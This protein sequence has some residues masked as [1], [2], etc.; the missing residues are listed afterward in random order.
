MATNTTRDA[1]HRAL[2]TAALGGG[3]T[4]SGLEALRIA[5]VLGF[6]PIA[7]GVIA[8]RPRMMAA[9]ERLGADAPT[10]PFVRELRERYG[11]GPLQLRIPGRRLA[12]VLTGTDAGRV[13]GGTPDP[14]NPANREKKGA[15]SPFQ[16]H[17]VLISEGHIR[18]ERRRVNEEALDTSHAMHHLAGPMVEVIRHEMAALMASVQAKGTLDNDEFT[19]TWWRMV[20]QIVL[21]KSARDDNTVTDQLRKLRSNGNWS[22]FLPQRRKL[23]DRFIESLYSY[24][25]KAEPGCVVSALAALPAGGAIDPVGQIPHWLFAFDAAGIASS[26]ALALLSSHPEQRRLAQEEI[27]ACDTAVPQQYP[28]LRACVLESVRLWPTTPTILRDSTSD[29]TWGAAD[30]EFTIPAGT[31]FLILAP[32]FHRDGETFSFAD[33][34]APA[35]WLDGMAQSRPELVPFSAGPAECPGRN[36]VLFVTSTMLALLL[37]AADFELTSTPAL[38]PERRLPPTL[39]NFGLR[40]RVTPR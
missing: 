17:G 27:A 26:R 32:A 31:A 36:L 15:L 28:Y 38:T 9:L 37:E 19:R 2:E 6:S 14:F 33:E 11:P 34:F 29:T 13:L 35:V 21:G 39:N 7:A 10:V 12:V 5:A 30:V 25:D 1:E 3:P 4:V 40:F 20:R 24:V 8:R 18:R 16:P 22:Y 23:H